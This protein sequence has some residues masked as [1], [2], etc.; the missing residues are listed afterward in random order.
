MQTD[1]NFA[2]FFFLL[3]CIYM[4]KELNKLGGGGGGGDL[5]IFINHLMFSTRKPVCCL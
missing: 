5:T 3:I 4:G 2:I 1:L